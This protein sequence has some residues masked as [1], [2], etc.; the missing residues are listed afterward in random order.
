MNLRLKISKKIGLGFG[1]LAFA[2][3]LSS[4]ITF[5]TLNNNRLINER[6]ANIYMPSVSALNDLYSMV[7]DSKMLIKNW[8]FIDS[9]SDTPGKK[10]LVHIHEKQYPI[11]KE[12][13][14][15]LSEQWPKKQENET[16][17][18]LKTIE[19]T[20]FR[21]HAFIMSLLASFEDYDRPAIV[22][23]ASSMVGEEN[24]TVMVVTNSVLNRLD[25]LIKY[26]EQKVV[27]AKT[28]M[29]RSFDRFQ[30]LII[31]ISI[32]LLFSVLIFAT[33]SIK[34]IVGPI[35]K[36]KE[37]TEKLGQ[38]DL[39]VSVNIRTGDELQSLAETFN[40]MTGNLRANRKKLREANKELE[41]K[42]E[43][44]ASANIAL[45]KGE[46][47][48]RELNSTKDKFFAI[49]AKDLKNP[50][51]SLL[52]ITQSLTE[53]YYDIEEED[54]H[55]YIQRVNMT[56]HEIYRLLEN[57]LEWSVSQIND[58]AG[59]PEE[60]DIKT[61]VDNNIY[62]LKSIADK[63]NVKLESNVDEHVYAYA[64]KNMINTVIRNLVSNA[65]R[66]NK[67]NGIVAISCQKTEKYLEISVRDTGIG[68]KPEKINDIF[69]IN[70]DSNGDNSGNSQAT[71]LGLYVS[72]EFVEKNGGEIKVISEPKE[73]SEF[74]FTLPKVSD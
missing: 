60:I 68:I 63:N 1:I 7:N 3:I 21:Q 46:K 67:P 65:I 17:Q 14:T 41:S 70:P 39:N 61:L 47:M 32:L 12:E 69:A 49:I 62:R 15:R 64:D 45:H 40:L 73:G 36:L 48:L 58:T 42:S 44:L 38:D 22:F 5:Y 4:A 51:T 31:T 52:S 33:Y 66:Y 16:N 54:R 26:H 55:F 29:K 23:E 25:T 43:R 56:A 13:I 59:N 50:L 74:I 8:V 30:A 6:I 24:D 71:G 28:L 37:A 19:D 20:L 53:S 57:L 27:D 35:K 34:T 72:K 18:L 10:R 9:K 11:L 2:V